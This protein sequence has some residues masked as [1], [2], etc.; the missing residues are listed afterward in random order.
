MNSQILDLEQCL[1]TGFI[2]K[3]FVSSQLFQPELLVN[4]GN[5]QKVVMA[6]NE[7]LQHCDRFWFSVAFVTTSGIACLKQALIEL[8]ENGIYGRILVSQYLNFTQPEA[9][10]QLLGF[11]NIEVRIAVDVNFH[12]KGYHFS[13]K[14]IDNLIVGSSN[15]TANALTLNKEW[16]LKVSSGENSALSKRVKEEFETEFENSTPVT[17]TF[18][19]EYKIIYNQQ[20]SLLK[21]LTNK[22]GAL[23]RDPVLPN[24]MQEE[25]L[26]NLISLRKNNCSKALLISATGTGKTFLSAFDARHVNPDRLLFVVHRA[27]IA[28]A[29]MKTFQAIFNNKK[30]FGLYSGNTTKLDQD[31]VFSTVQTLSRDEHLS[32]FERD[33]FDY[34][35][36]DETHRAAANS[37]QKILNHFNAKFVLGMTATPERTDGADVFKI[38]DYNIA[39]EI[40]LQKALEMNI[41]SPFHYYGITDVSVDNVI[42]D[43]SSPLNVLTSKERIRHIFEQIALYGCD[44]GIVRGLVF[45]A[46]INEC[47]QLSAAFNQNGFKTIALTGTHTEAQR[48]KAIEGLESSN[49]STKLDYIFTV[50]IFNEGIDIPC[51]NQIVMLRPTESSIIFVQQLGRGLRK[52]DDKEFLTV[53][54]FIGNYT[55]NFLVPIALF[56]DESYNKDTLRK[57]MTGSGGL[58]PG[59]ST[60]NFDKIAKE[61]I[62]K[63]IDSAKLQ[64]KKD[65]QNDYDLLKY[66]LGRTPLMMDFIENGSRDPILFVNH[67]KSLFNFSENC[68]PEL[69]GL[70]TEKQKKILEFFSSEIN[71]GKRVGESFILRELL[72][73]SKISVKVLMKSIKIDYR[74]DISAATI[75]SMVR[76]LNM[77]FITEKYDKKMKSVS[78]IY[79]YKIVQLSNNVISWDQDFTGDLGNETFKNYLVDSANY[80]LT[81]FEKD[82]SSSE[83]FG[84][85]QLYRKYSRKDVFRILNWEKNPV[86]QNVGGYIVSKDGSNCPIFVNY[87]KADDISVTTKYEDHFISESKF[88]WMSKSSRNLSSPDV[89]TIKKRGCA[90]TMRIPLFIKKSNDEGVEFYYMGDIRPQKDSFEETTMASKR[91]AVSVVKI[92]FDMHCTVRRDIFEYLLSK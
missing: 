31:F 53:I 71:N 37:Y 20:K 6:I 39:Y 16:N 21:Q 70:L 27:N 38:F 57:L 46:N 84:G 34:I 8:E 65:L 82:F 3:E 33:R 48:D 62:Y 86:A 44:N 29:A 24:E 30:T 19:E 13:R 89:E 49:M 58:I 22:L 73:N 60:V 63:A 7:Q 75:D 10:R 26:N 9:L 78:E 90:E 87:H 5:K 2:D 67:S 52:A 77:E 92:T 50:G 79:G 14:D 59:S 12:A 91:G 4:D 64:R 56:G 54:D 41:L 36:I 18:I 68:E 55:N 76:N 15:F 66:R 28:K 43:D 88:S 80:S 47:N 74:H 35:V 69:K 45:C 40:R 42:I 83:F 51:V 23:T 1:R 25:A 11:K 85:F 81:N 72:L 32:K 17:S 61:R